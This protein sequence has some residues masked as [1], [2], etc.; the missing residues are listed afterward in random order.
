MFWSSNSCPPI[1]S[2]SRYQGVTPPSVAAIGIDS[3]Y[4]TPESFSFWTSV[5]SSSKVAGN[6]SSPGL[7]EHLL[8]VH[9]DA[10]I[11]RVAGR[12]GLAARGEGG[13]GGLEVGQRLCVDQALQR[14]HPAGACELAGERPVELGHVG[15]VGLG[16]VGDQQLVVGGVPSG[17]DV[18]DL[19]AGLGRELVEQLLRHHV[20]HHDG[21][22][23]A[24]D[25][26]GRAAARAR[27]TA[28]RAAAAGRRGEGEERE[29]GAD[30]ETLES[31]HCA[32]LRSGWTEYNSRRP[33]IRSIR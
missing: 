16:L 13:V 33:P 21:D 24:L 25:R 32:I 19:D 8:V 18:V 22:R 17:A 11:V 29:Q 30:G 15:D 26:L 7:G 10:E 1:A 23:L 9:G 31:C 27:I 4:W 12:V 14:L 5:A 20:R 28:A 2:V 6:V 3:G